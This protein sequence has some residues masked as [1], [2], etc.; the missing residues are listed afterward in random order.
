MDYRE[1]NKSFTIKLVDVAK[2]RRA[3]YD[4][5]KTQGV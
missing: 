4:D 2:M 1:G 5:S 3:D